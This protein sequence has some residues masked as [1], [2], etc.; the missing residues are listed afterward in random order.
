MSSVRIPVFFEGYFVNDIDAKIAVKGKQDFDF[1]Q[2]YVVFDLETT[3]LSFEKDAITEIGAAI[4][5]NGKME[6][7]FQ[8]FVDPG[9]KLP[10]KIVELTGITDDMLKGAPKAEEAIPAFLEFCGDRP[11]AAHN[12]DF[13]VSFV[14]AACQRLGLPFAPTYLDTLVMAQG[15]LPGLNKYCLLYTSRCV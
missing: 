7:R 9:R 2:E 12:A 4:Y 10:Q 8:T 15:L 5:C 3:G 11:L 13:D 6:K 14:K 1:H